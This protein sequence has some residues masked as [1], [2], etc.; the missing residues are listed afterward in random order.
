MES[1]IEEEAK[2][3]SDYLQMLRRRKY[4][5]IIPMLILLIL[6]VVVALVLPPVY[7]SEATVL[8]EQQH[9]PTDFVQSTV[10][11]LADERIRQ[12]E[13]KIMTIDN[14]NK[15]IDKYNLYAEQKNKL[16]STELINR[17]KSLES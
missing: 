16:S 6:S 7:R 3:L 4:L 17:L 8:I 10:M 12:I 11:S 15:I 13:Q 2:S 9:I 1:E 5:I 14:I